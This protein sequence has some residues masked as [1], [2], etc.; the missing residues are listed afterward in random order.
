MNCGLL[1]GSHMETKLGVVA[2]GPPISGVSPQ[3]SSPFQE[4]CEDAVYEARLRYGGR[5]DDFHSD[6]KIFQICEE[7]EHVITAASR[8]TQTPASL[9]L[10]L[11]LLGFCR[12]P[13]RTHSCCTHLR[14]PGRATAGASGSPASSRRKDTRGCGPA[15]TEPRH[16]R[17]TV[18]VRHGGKRGT[19]VLWLLKARPSSC[20]FA[21]SSGPSRFPCKEQKLLCMFTRQFYFLLTV[22]ANGNI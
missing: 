8:E 15:E 21:W 10:T 20:W 17:R 13:L 7:P 9:V 2:W 6:S 1:L 11:C 4:R 18:R 19:C 14:D 3:K 16:V 22:V 5:R 12:K